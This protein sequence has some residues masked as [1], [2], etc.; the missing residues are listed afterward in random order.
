MCNSGIC[1]FYFCLL[2]LTKELPQVCFCPY[3]QGISH[4]VR[5]QT[6]FLSGDIRNLLSKPEISDSFC[7]SDR[8]G[9]RPVSYIAGTIYGLKIRYLFIIKKIEVN[10]NSCLRGHASYCILNT[11]R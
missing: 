5:F 6:C 10:K 7:I 4:I 11:T 3:K 8:S 1:F 9:F 2:K